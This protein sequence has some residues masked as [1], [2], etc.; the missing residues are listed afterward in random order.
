[1]LTSSIW[2]R[3]RWWHDTTTRR[4]WTQT[5]GHTKNKDTMG[6]VN[7]MPDDRRP[8]SLFECLETEND[9]TH[10]QMLQY[11]SSHVENWSCHK[12]LKWYCLDQHPRNSWLLEPTLC[13]IKIYL[14]PS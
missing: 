3:R 8:K 2:R 6:S 5:R 4:A 7:S 13:I 9:W 14:S 10:S 11:T 12:L 1:L